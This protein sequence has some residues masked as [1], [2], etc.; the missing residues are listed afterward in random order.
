MDTMERFGHFTSASL[1]GLPMKTARR[2]ADVEAYTY[3]R[4]LKRRVRRYPMFHKKSYPPTLKLCMH[5]II[6]S[7]VYG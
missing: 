4:N 7:S 2:D 3:W 5:R 1:H 6:M